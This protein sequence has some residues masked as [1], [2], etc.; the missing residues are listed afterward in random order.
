MKYLKASELSFN[1]RPQM[2]KIFAEGFYDHGLK[3]LCKNK[4][5]LARATEHIF[6]LENFYVA[7]ENENEIA[8]FVGCCA[9][10]PP[11][12]TLDKKILRREMGFFHGSI[13]Y[14][15]L[16]KVLIQKP[17]PFE[18]PLQAASIEFVATAPEHR[19]KGAAF[20]LLS[21][22]MEVEPYNSYVLEVVGINIAAIRLYEKLGF[23]EFMRVPA[24]KGSKLEQFVYMKKE[25]AYRSSG[26]PGGELAIA[27][28]L[29]R[30][31]LARNKYYNVQLVTLSNQLGF[32]FIL[33]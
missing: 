2:A 8:A 5:E 10:K 32:C 13:V 25:G 27:A 14:F 6:L 28:K 15:A 12:V 30:N 1:P 11:P 31:F 21:H 33:T 22:V 16:N 23:V 18:Q 4:E 29:Q 7:I 20:G 19:G 17:Y 26:S 9:K 3:M 24:P